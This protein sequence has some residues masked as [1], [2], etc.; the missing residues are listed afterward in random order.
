ML[1]AYLEQAGSQAQAGYQA[2]AGSLV[3]PASQE[4]A[5][6]LVPAMCLTSP[7]QQQTQ[8]SIQ[9]LWMGEELIL[10]RESEAQQPV[11]VIIQEQAK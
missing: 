8:H 10:L 5:V 3:F 7:T 2:Q 9:C 1:A 4:R 11:S 6:L